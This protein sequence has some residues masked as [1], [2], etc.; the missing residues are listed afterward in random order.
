MLFAVHEMEN[1]L[2]LWVVP[3]NPGA[4]PAIIVS[5]DSG[6]TRRREDTNRFRPDLKDLR[7]HSTGNCGF[8]M[9]PENLPEMAGDDPF[10]IY[11]AESNLLVY[12]RAPKDCLRTRVLFLHGQMMER[13]NLVRHLS[14]DFQMVY[15]D[16]EFI[17]E[18]ALIHIFYGFSTSCLVSGAFLFSNYRGMVE[19]QEYIRT[20]LLID[21]VWELAASLSVLRT[22]A[23]TNPVSENW[24]NLGRDSLVA[25]FKDVDLTSPGEINRAIKQL[26]EHDYTM[27]CN[28]LVRRFSAKLIDEPIQPSHV[29]KALDAIADFEVIGFDDE[30]EAFREHLSDHLDRDCSMIE[31]E[32]ATPQFAAIVEAV[33]RARS[34]TE[35]LVHDFEFYEKVRGAYETFKD[36]AASAA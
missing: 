11:E 17:P 1:S 26:G 35:M 33:S 18:E 25:Q 15:S 20:A 23:H 24:R 9:T 7:I 29:P 27:L 22:I 3:D 12:R 36:E 5:T 30:F 34:A 13:C 8:L 21:P 28:P 16:V 19:R 6:R 32:Q 2:D 14:N 4:A 31:H 10:E